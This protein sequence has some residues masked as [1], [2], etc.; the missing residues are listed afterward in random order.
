MGDK[1][2]NGI[3]PYLVTPL[4]EAGRLKEQTLADLVEHLIRKGVH[5]LTPLGST[6][7]APYLDWETKRRTVEVTVQAA[8]GRVPV[9][10][11]VCNL[12]TPGAVREA[13]ETEKLGADGILAVMPGYFPLNDRQIVAHFRAVARAVTCP[14]TLYT[15]PKFQTWDFSVEALRE[16]AE[17]PNI[18]YLK[19]ASGN[20]GKL[21]S[22]VTALGDRIKLFSDTSS[23]PLFVFLIGGVGWMSGPACVIPEQSIALYESPAPVSKAL[24]HGLLR[25]SAGSSFLFQ[26]PFFR[27]APQDG[28][29]PTSRRI[30]SSALRPSESSCFCGGRGEPTGNPC[31]SSPALT[32][33]AREYRWKATL[34]GHCFF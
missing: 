26:Q 19:D 15:N 6:G 10:A 34:R 12:S 13:A 25:W 5:G 30:F 11:G 1:A 23:V 31:I 17:E 22:I 7:E 21:M 3:F 9:V 18:Q 32:H 28:R 24:Q 2:F 14:V 16:L 20:V 8:A 33:A 27:R 29:A 4:T